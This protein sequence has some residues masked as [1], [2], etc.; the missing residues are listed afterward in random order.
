MCVF[1][2]LGVG[3]VC[4]L[5]CCFALFMCVRYCNVRS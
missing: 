1:V 4:V 5:L 2:V 3:F